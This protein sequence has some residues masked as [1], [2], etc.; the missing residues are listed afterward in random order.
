MVDN[1]NSGG[2]SPS[3]NK[4]SWRKR[5]LRQRYTIMQDAVLGEG[6]FATVYKGLDTEACRNVAVKV[7]NNTDRAT[8]EDFK[9]SVAVLLS[10]GDE[11]N[12]VHG[13]KWSTGRGSFSFDCGV[14][15]EEVVKSQSLT[16]KTRPKGSKLSPD[17]EP[18][19]PA[20]D[21]AETV[22]KRVDFR[23]CFVELLDYSRDASGDAGPDN[24]EDGI[25]YLIIEIGEES[26]DE[27]LTACREQGISLT[28]EELRELQWALVAIVWALHAVGFVHMDI[29]PCNIMR[30]SAEGFPDQWKL[31]DLDGADKSGTQVKMEDC[32][33]TPEYMPPELAKQYMRA[34][35]GAKLGAITLSRL[36]DVWSVGM[37]SLE[38]I[39]LQP[40]LRPWFEQWQQETG[41]DDKFYDWL[42]NYET[43]P[44]LSGELREL[45]HDIDKDMCEV[46]EGMLKKNPE[47]RTDIAQ[48]VLHKWFEPVRFKLLASMTGSQRSASNA[49]AFS[50]SKPSKDKSRACVSM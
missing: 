47:K 18:A 40:V 6:S 8:L 4:S 20:A 44:I 14:L 48:A 25:V 45:I 23:S 42:A 35:S 26:L 27:R 43:E 46:L 28:V 16:K 32:T 34:N 38:A 9:K 37:V 10:I 19:A 30:F 1:G 49:S 7:Y 2:G 17:M 22:L 50:T 39:F 21:Q 11:A 15:E 29:K 41:D 12:A 3:S 31:I 24:D 33:F 36:M 5:E 13:D